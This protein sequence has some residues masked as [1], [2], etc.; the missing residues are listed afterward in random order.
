[1]GLESIEQKCLKY[2]MEVSNPLVPI[3]S[4]LRFLQR[5]PEFAAMESGEL[6]AFLRKH[7]LFRVLEPP[8][9]SSDPQGALELAQA[10]IPMQLRVMLCTRKPT[11]AQMVEYMTQEVRNVCEALSFS[12][13]AANKAGN[14]ERAEKLKAALQRA[15]LIHSRLEDL[16]P[17]KGEEDDV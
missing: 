3:E 17:A 7:E 1:M 12:L 11:D 10:G 14:H 6:V 9:L 5:E 4:L 13:K 15:R 16:G 2:L 8:I